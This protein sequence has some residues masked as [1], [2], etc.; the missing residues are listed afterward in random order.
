MTGVLP[1][2]G[3]ESPRVSGTILG[4]GLQWRRDAP[5]SGA[6]SLP[7]TVATFVTNLPS[8][9]GD[10]EHRA[11]FNKS[12]TGVE[13]V[14][15][16]AQVYGPD[17]GR[18]PRGQGAH[19]WHPCLRRGHLSSKSAAGN[20]SGR[21]TPFLN[22]PSPKHPEKRDASPYPGGEGTG[23][24]MLA[25]PTRPGQ[26]LSRAPEKQPEPRS[27]TSCLWEPGFSGEK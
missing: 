12:S 22:L 18:G 8:S 1:P 24:L 25:P 11:R 17:R 2:A 21:K 7:H 9:L 23:R 14:K 19:A 10:R 20:S 3:T 26:A 15:A 27:Q 6:W 5:V 16:C 13:R 4:T